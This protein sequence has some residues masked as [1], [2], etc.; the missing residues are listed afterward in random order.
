MK[1]Y[2][3][4]CKHGHVVGRVVVQPSHE[5]VLEVFWTSQQPGRLLLADD[6]VVDAAVSVV[7]SGSGDVTCTL[8]G[9]VRHWEIGQA[10]LD[11]LIERVHKSRQVVRNGR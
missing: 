3:W 4:L 9:D 7:L 10:T 2:P 8:C 5:Q 6:R 1:V 11:R